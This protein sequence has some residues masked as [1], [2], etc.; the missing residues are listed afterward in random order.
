M[1]VE[2]EAKFLNVSHEVMRAKLRELGA[3]CEQP[4]RTMQ[5]VILDFPNKS[6]YKNH[7][8]ARVRDEGDKVTITYKRDVEKSFGS[9]EEIEVVADSYQQATKLMEALGLEV[10]SRQESKRETWH[11]G[12]VEV[13]LDEWPWIPPF[14]EIEGHAKQDVQ[15]VAEQL[16]LSWEQA[17]FG[18][19]TNAYRHHFPAME[20]GRDIGSIPKIAFNSEPPAWFGKVQHEDN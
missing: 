18:S 7:A 16:G 14:I 17:V 19:V 11:L 10:L 15:Q 6:L 12:A 3:V 2:I 8:W 20:P 1:D 13:V 5:R 4:L 9:V